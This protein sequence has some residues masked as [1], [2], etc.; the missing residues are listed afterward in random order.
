M[1]SLLPVIAIPTYKRASLISGLTLK[2]LKDSNYPP[3]LIRLFVA[4]E[5]EA[6]E[7]RTLV[8]RLLYYVIIVGVPGLKEQRKFISN[9]FPEDQIIVQMDDD[10]KNIKTHPTMSFID[11]VLK[12]VDAV[13]NAVGLWGVM[14]NDDGRK[15]REET[16]IHLAHILGSFF[17]CKN[18]REIAEAIMTDD[19]E[20]FERSILYF[21]AYGAVAR[22][23]GA[24][25]LTDYQKTPGGLQQEGRIERQLASIRYM[26]ETY[27]GYVTAVN[28]PK[29]QDITLNWRAI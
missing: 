19:K 2:F 22:Y 28:K 13:E 21:Q 14:P 16:T 10:V 1:S 15:M 26:L 5:E 23:K 6:E 25:V 3:Y 24:G 27:P 17:I 29:G 11:L 4:S 12:G 9:Y 20:D 7:Y 8:P 18:D